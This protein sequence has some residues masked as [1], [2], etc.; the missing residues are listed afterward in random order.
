MSFELDTAQR[1]RH[2]AEQLRT[3]AERE[4][5]GLIQDKLL[6]IA[7]DYDRMASDLETID[8]SN[9]SVRRN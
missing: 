3:I 9:Q 1:Y 6:K 5:R 4:C 2:R 8:A 7:A